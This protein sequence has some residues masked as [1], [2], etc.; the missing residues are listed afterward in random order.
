[1]LSCFVEL[2]YICE[3]KDNRQKQTNNDVLCLFC[4]KNFMLRLIGKKLPFLTI[5]KAVA[6]QFAQQPSNLYDTDYNN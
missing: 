5:A 2:M 3:D 4:T 6:G 1:M